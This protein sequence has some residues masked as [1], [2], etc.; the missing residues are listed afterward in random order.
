MTL[1]SKVIGLALS[2]LLVSTAIA[3]GGVQ[4][5]RTR[6][7]MKDGATKTAYALINNSDG[8]VLASG[9]I[10]NLDGSPTTAMTVSPSIY[11]VKSKGTH[12]G[13]IL[14]LE[15]LPQDRESVFWLNVKTITPEK[16]DGSASNM[17]FAI[18]Q[19]IK[20]FYRPKDVKQDTRIAAEKLLWTRTKDGIKAVNSSQVS[21]TLAEISAGNL[22]KEL[23]DVLL[24]MSEIEWKYKLSN[25]N[26]MTFTYVD[27]YGN[28]VKQPLKIKN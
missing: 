7:H 22:K 28:F 17:Q 12:Q 19:R 23:S 6:V 11:Q 4:L 15:P 27:E 8:P 26:E 10:T 9:T 16:T 2:T 13:S 18:G 3:A 20:V 21:L 1:I 5:D 14:L 24:P 25:A